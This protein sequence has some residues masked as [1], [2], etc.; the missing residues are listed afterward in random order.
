MR[1]SAIVMNDLEPCII[2]IFIKNKGSPQETAK[3]LTSILRGKSEDQTLTIHRDNIYSYFKKLKREYHIDVMKEFS[4]LGA[5][6]QSDL[7][8]HEAKDRIGQYYNALLVKILQILKDA[9]TVEEQRKCVKTAMD[10]ILPALK[11]HGI[12]KQDVTNINVQVN[13]IQ[14]LDKLCE[15]FVNEFGDKAIPVIN[16]VRNS[17]LYSQ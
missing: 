2:P 5:N 7:M 17:G 10:L 8:I 9:N 13:V 12:V 15:E 3:E 16:K 1:H 14:I 6:R 4:T 11:T